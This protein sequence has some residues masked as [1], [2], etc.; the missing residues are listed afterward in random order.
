MR[1]IIID[2]ERPAVKILENFVGRL[3]FLELVLATTNVFEGLEKLNSETVDLLF[4]D[5]QMPDITGIELLNSLEKKPLVIFTTAYDEYALQGY[6]L[7]IVDYLIKPIPFQRFLKGANKAWKLHQ[8][9]TPITP[10]ES[11]ISIKS[12][13]KTKR[14]FH[15]DI[16]YIEGL[17]D[18]VKIYTTAGM[19]L[20]RLNLKGIE[21]QLPSDQFVRIHR[22]YIAALSKIETYQ[23]SQVSI[24]SK[25]LPIGESYRNELLK[26]LS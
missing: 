1:T 26:K 9:G 25:T 18:Y 8:N 3:P 11:F 12:D 23:K 24:G 21:Q 15:R 7:D 22:S 17:K 4:L 19:D 5:I 2:D 6:E 10:P 20:T 16:L 13:Y 14:I